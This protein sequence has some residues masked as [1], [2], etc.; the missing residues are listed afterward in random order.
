MPAKACRT[1]VQA[2]DE[3]VIDDVE[4]VEV[5]EITSL[6]EIVPHEPAPKPT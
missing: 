1:G 6:M 5:D 3:L 4:R 2:R